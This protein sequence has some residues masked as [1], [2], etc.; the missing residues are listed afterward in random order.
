MGVPASGGTATP[1]SKVDRA[2]GE[3]S[4]RWPH[5]LPGGKV[6]LHSLGLGST[7]DNAK[8][9]AQ[10]LDTG[11]R[12]VVLNGGCDAR[13]VPPG[14]LVYVRGNSLYAVPFDAEALEVRGQPTWSW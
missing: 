8:V 2:A 14:H 13:Y 6:V 1:V 12:K 9:V 7:W 5:A 11:E 3:R 10:R 4:H